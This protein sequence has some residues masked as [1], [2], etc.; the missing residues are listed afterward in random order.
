MAQLASKEYLSVHSQ[1]KED[2][3]DSDPACPDPSPAGGPGRR[4]ARCAVGRGACQTAT[5][6][7]GMGPY[8]CGDGE[9]VPPV[10][11][12]RT[13]YPGARGG[14]DRPGGGADPTAPALAQRWV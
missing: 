4:R 3:N 13:S 8:S 14:A 5:E 9:L 1:P 7:G 10:G 11:R 6:T 12:L 2:G